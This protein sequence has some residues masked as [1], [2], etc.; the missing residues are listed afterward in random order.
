[1][2]P[3]QLKSKKRFSQ[4]QQKSGKESDDADLCVVP[5]TQGD[6]DAMTFWTDFDKRGKWYPEENSFKETSIS[7]PTFS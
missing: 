2:P 7:L 5:V 6:Q 1:M 3:I 4:F